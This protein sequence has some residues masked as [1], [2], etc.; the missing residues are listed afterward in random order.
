MSLGFSAV[1]LTC[2]AMADG[3]S[4]QRHKEC[5]K[6]APGSLEYCQET[7]ADESSFQAAGGAEA[8]VEDKEKVAGME[9]LAD[10]YGG[11][12]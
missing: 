5:N 3:D 12:I 10:D 8:K 11:D 6:V 1:L 2:H 9:F 4:V 7:C